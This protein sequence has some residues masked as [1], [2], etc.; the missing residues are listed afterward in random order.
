MLE[1][2]IGTI[3]S[4]P[5]NPVQL[6]VIGAAHGIRGEVRVKPYTEDPLSIGDYGLLYDKQGNSYEVLDVRSAKTVVIVR[7]RGINDR[8][9]AEVLN[10]TE[11]FIDRSQLTDE[12]DDD[13]FYYADLIGL[14]AY[15]KDGHN[16]GRIHAL[17]DFGGGD[18]IELR[19]T[20]RKPML[21]PF[22][23][24]A[25][26]EIDLTNGKIIVDPYAAGLIADQ[27]DDYPEDGYD[28]ERDREA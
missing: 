19:L 18:L 1:Q 27:D 8:N 4:R 14:Q 28:D 26:T 7:F 20:G 17:F 23:E 12:L 3:M 6:A 9:A 16:H 10:G 15:D 21:I 5:E 25:V 22:T 2:L 13:E 11:L 24:A